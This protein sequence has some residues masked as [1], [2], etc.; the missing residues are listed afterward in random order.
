[1]V[2]NTNEIQIDIVVYSTDKIIDESKELYGESIRFLEAMSRRFDIYW[3]AEPQTEEVDRNKPREQET[4]TQKSIPGRHPKPGYDAA[5][6]KVLSGKTYREAFNFWKNE[7][8]SE[9]N[10]LANDDSFSDPY[11]LFK[12]AM[13]HRHRKRKAK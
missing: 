4:S 1:M 3:K 5:F 11:D 2:I 7:Y 9:Y 10:A 6:V 13:N 8:P 12:S